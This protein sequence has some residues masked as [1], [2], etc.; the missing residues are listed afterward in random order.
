MTLLKHESP[1]PQR[2]QFI[3]AI[4]MINVRADYGHITDILPKH[5]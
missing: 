5:P 2:L 1:Q 4:S 3:T